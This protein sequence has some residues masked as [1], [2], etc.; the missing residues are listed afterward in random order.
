MKLT[1]RQDRFC[2]EYVVDFNARQA[3][4]RAGYAEKA[5]TVC[6]SKMLTKSHIQARVAELNSK[7]NKATDFDAEWIRRKMRELHDECIENPGGNILGAAQLRAKL[8]ENMGKMEGQY[9]DKHELTG[10]SQ[11]TFNIKTGR[12]NEC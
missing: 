10:R 11:I 7:V 6:A 8:L 1:A 9:V 2:R 3:Y 5:A 12:K 4:I